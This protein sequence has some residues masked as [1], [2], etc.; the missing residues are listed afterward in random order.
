[1]VQQASEMVLL[2]VLAGGVL[3]FSGSGCGPDPDADSRAGRRESPAS[4]FTPDLVARDDLIPVGEPAPDF[5]G[6]NQRGDWLTLS[7]LLK[8][9]SVVLIFYPANNTPVCTKQLCAVRDDWS[10][11]QEKGATVLGINPASVSKHARF[12]EKHEFPFP[13]ICDADSL[14]AKAYGAAGTLFVQRSVYVIGRDG[15]VLLADRGVVSHER[16]LAALGGP[17]GAG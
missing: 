16:I 14:I 5:A 13:V 17:S 15:K 11:F 4:R 1:M 10:K 6:Q 7:E 2:F 3:W 12:A 9:R 8:T